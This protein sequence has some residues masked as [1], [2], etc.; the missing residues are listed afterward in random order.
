MSK[1][2]HT[3][4]FTTELKVTVDESKFTEEFMEEYRKHF[5]PYFDVED[6]VKH[7]ARLAAIGDIDENSFIEGYG[8]AKDFGISF[9]VVDEYFS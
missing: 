8:F 4:Q 3:V 2:T 9:E 1:V 5:F 7:I 6:H